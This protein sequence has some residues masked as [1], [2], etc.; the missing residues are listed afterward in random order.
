MR[1]EKYFIQTFKILRPHY[2]LDLKKISDLSSLFLGIVTSVTNYLVTEI[3]L[4][5]Y[6]NIR[7]ILEKV[8]TERHHKNICISTQIGL[9]FAVY[10]LGVM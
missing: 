6:Q 8:G 1:L 9:N 10:H 3:N 2:I 4:Y 7:E 5:S